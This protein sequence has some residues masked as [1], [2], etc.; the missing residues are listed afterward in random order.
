MK[1]KMEDCS[2]VTTVVRPANL[3]RSC[4]ISGG[5]SVQRSTRVC[6]SNAS[7]GRCWTSKSCV[8][9]PF[10]IALVVASCM[11]LDVFPTAV[12]GICV[13]L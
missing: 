12:N 6:M 5:T 11:I 8:E 3:E 2:R 1:M 10:P 9:D 7:R 13:S 4:W